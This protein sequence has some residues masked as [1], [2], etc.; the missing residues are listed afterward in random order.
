MRSPD[1]DDVEF[2]EDDR[3]EGWDYNAPPPLPPIELS[4]DQAVAFERIMQWY[5]TA[6]IGM[7]A[8][9]LRL[10]G[11]AGTGKTTLIRR[12][13]EEIGASRV[14]VC[15]YTGKAAH[16]LRGKGL[17]NASTIHSL[18]YMPY[19]IC[20]Y[21]KHEVHERRCDRT[22]YCSK[23]ETETHFRTADLLD[24]DLIIVDEA[25]MVD[26]QI[27]EDL[28]SFGCPILYVGDHG[29]LEPIGSNPH[30]MKDPDIRLEKIHRQAEDSPIIRFAHRVRQHGLPQTEGEAARVEYRTKSPP[31][32][33]TYDIVLCGRNKTRVALN[34]KIRRSLGFSGELPQRGERIVCLRNSKDQNLF[35]G[36]LATVLD[37][38]T[39]EDLPCPEL[40]LID[41]DGNVRTGVPFV[42]E[43][44]GCEETLDRSSRRR[45]LF[46]FGYALTVHKCVSGDTLVQTQLGWRRMDEIDAAC[47]QVATSEGPS[48]YSAY[49]E[50][51][52]DVLLELRCEQ[53][54]F[55]S[56]TP[57]HKLRTFG[58]DGWTWREARALAIGDYLRL[59]LGEHGPHLASD[60]Q[61]PAMP[62]A[63]A[64]SRSVSIPATLSNDLAEFLG[65][66][67]AD[68][69]LIHSGARLAK[70]HLDVVDRFS[71]LARSLFGVLPHRFEI[72]G[73]PAAEFH[74]RPVVEWLRRIG[75]LDPNHKR[76]PEVVLSAAPS[77]RARFFR[78]LFEDG[79][80]NVKNGAVDHVEWANVS[81][82]LV[83]TVQTLLL[84]YGII[85]SVAHRERVSSL[86]IYADGLDRFREAI[87]FVSSAKMDRL[88]LPFADRPGARYRVP[89]RRSDFTCC[90]VIG[91]NARARGYVSRATARE[92]GLVEDL[93]FHYVRIA[94]ISE[95]IGPSYCLTV[96]SKGA[97]LQN[98][99]DGA[100]S[101][102]SEWGRVLVLEWIHPDTSASRWR[103]TAAT[104]ASRELVW[105]MRKPSGRAATGG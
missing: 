17:A 48:S 73:T 37:V 81:P 76:I 63:D 1:D 44:F 11:Y 101:Q 27:H 23:A 12:I 25:S 72:A 83:A 24:T 56:V 10:G 103:Y 92:L 94:Q 85:C 15:A 5:R 84:E 6:R 68:G 32:L 21:C 28:L 87:G 50:R 65:L 40:D 98:R 30:L 75:G 80:V 105:C 77:I 33:H 86:Y 19:Q 31:D 4:P 90:T 61:L 20:G 100:N 47:G 95:S 35:N 69:S 58:P 55:V 60:P 13:V 22:Q 79:T 102:G 42:A 9:M 57:D 49:I 53:G 88:S 99:F 39:H 62:K 18:I 16:V 29:Q 26:R 93:Q 66:M 52:A 82:D 71:D 36:M 3:I 14:S 91:Q 59:A 51:N 45:A 43:Q 41:D 64:R 54:Y 34:A 7:K 2:D 74:S 89:V 78:G 8:P 97:F 70:R 46:D 67:V 104:R 96:P 38:D